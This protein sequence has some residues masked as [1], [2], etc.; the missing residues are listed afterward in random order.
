MGLKHTQ[1]GGRS[2]DGHTS[3]GRLQEKRLRTTALPLAS[4]LTVSILL[5]THTHTAV[6]S[7]ASGLL[8]LDPVLQR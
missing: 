7:T 2:G 1:G 5:S 6:S 8:E 3:E 4:T